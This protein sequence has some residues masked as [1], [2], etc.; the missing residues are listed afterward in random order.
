MEDSNIK[1]KSGLVKNASKDFIFSVLAL[2][3]YNGVLQLLIYPEIEHR[4][5]EDAFGTVLYLISAVSIMGAG[6]GTAASYSRMMAKKNREEKNGDYNVFLLII[7]AISVPVTLGSLYLAKVASIGLF[8]PVLVLMIVTVFRYYADVQ[9]RMTI[10]FKEYFLFFA[11]TSVGYVLGLA[12]Y[13][14]TGSWVFVLLLGELFGIVFTV[15]TGKIFRA[16]F[17]ELSGCF[18][19]NMIS[20]WYISFSNLLAALILHSDRILLR[21]LVGEGKEV[22][23][24]YTASLVGKIVAM[25]TTPLNGIVISYLT[26]Y[27]IEMNK[28]RFAAIGVACM[29]LTVIGAAACCV[30][31]MIFVKWRYPDIYAAASSYF[32]LANLGQLLYFISGS[33]MVVLLAFTEEKLQFIINLVYGIAFVIIVIPATYMFGIVGIAYGLVIVNTVRFITVILLGVIKLGKNR[34]RHE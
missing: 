14:V 32:F 28:K 17:F 8:I 26:N 22:T 23:I 30:G 20:A 24:F 7:A 13:P 27:K 11:S 16:P 34:I 10:R 18:K 31:S 2:V 21:I 25:L 9:Y 4:V 29:G 12:L 3:I 6:F 5:G 15:I 1:N 33:L 19:E